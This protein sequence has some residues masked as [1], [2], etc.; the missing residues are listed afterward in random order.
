MKD[1]IKKIIR[2][3]SISFSKFADEI[4]VLRSSVSHILTGRNNPSLEFVQKVLNRYRNIN[5]EWLIYGKGEM[6]KIEK[7]KPDEITIQQNNGLQTDQI[8]SLDT[9]TKEI[10]NN[11]SVI[12]KMPK[13]KE[14]EKVIL[15]YDDGTFRE[16]YS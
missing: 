14:V 7:N 9:N 10:I 12:A 15:F 6:Y 16:Y 3:E 2:D 11:S 8:S 4:G 1:R 13:S 5:I